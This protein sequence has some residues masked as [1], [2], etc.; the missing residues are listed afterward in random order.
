[1][2]QWMVGGVWLV[3]GLHLVWLETLLTVA[4]RWLTMI[5]RVGACGVLRCVHAE[6]NEPGAWF[7]GALQ[8]SSSLHPGFF[9]DSLSSCTCMGLHWT[10]PRR[11]LPGCLSTRLTA[12][13][14]QVLRIASSFTQAQVNLSTGIQLWLLVRSL[15][16][17]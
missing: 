4:R 15:L 17:S 3:P 11:K 16:L 14:Q 1:M 10:S 2:V 9:V 8:R 6:E 7:A 12:T 5:V 13:A